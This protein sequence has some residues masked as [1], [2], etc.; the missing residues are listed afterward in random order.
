MAAAVIMPML[1][2]AVWPRKLWGVFICVISPS[3]LPIRA[4]F[5]GLVTTIG[6]LLWGG[7]LKPIKTIKY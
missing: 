1:R 7:V 5:R 4:A 3:S 6:Y 2:L